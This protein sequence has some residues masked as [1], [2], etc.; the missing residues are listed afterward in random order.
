MCLFSGFASAAAQVTPV[1]QNCRVD[2]TNLLFDLAAWPG[3]YIIAASTNTAGAWIPE[4]TITVGRAGIVNIVVPFT[5]QKALFFGARG[6]TPSDGMGCLAQFQ[7]L[8]STF[9][10]EVG[11]DNGL[12]RQFQW[13]WSDGTTSSDYPIAAKDFGTPDARIQGLLANPMSSVASINLGFDG[14]DGGASTPLSNRP[15]QNV[16]AVLFPYPLPSLRYWASAYNPITNTLDFSGFTNLQVIECYSCTNLQHVVVTNLPALTRACIEICQL[17]E[18]DLS[19]NPEFQDLRGAF[20][21]YTNIIVGRGTGPKIRHWCVGRNPQLRQN[22]MDLI[23]NFY[24]LE[25]LIVSY[26]SQSGALAIPSTNLISVNASGNAYSVADFTGRSTLSECL[27]Y[28]NQ[29]TNVMLSGC[30]GLQYLDAHN[31]RISSID[32][33]D[34]PGLDYLDLHDNQLTTL[35]TTASIELEY[36]DAHGNQLTNAVLNGCAGL[37]FVDLHDN[38]LPAEILDDL[39]AFL[40]ASAPGVTNVNLTG[41]AGAPSAIGYDHYVSLTNRGVT[42]LVDW[43]NTNNVPG[44]PNAITFVTTSSDPHMEIRTNSGAAVSILWHWGDGATTTNSLLADHDFGSV[45]RFTNYV[46]VI[47]PSSVTYFG[48]QWTITG[49]GIEAVFGASNFPNLQYL[50]LYNESVAILSLAGCSNLVQLHLAGNPVPPDVCDQ[51]FI[52]LDNAVPGPVTSADFWYP[53]A[54]RSSASDA[55]WSSLAKKGYAMHPS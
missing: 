10:P 4:M 23:T 1:L 11:C 44:G 36:L 45:G 27:L 14:I 37:K 6:A 8:E 40:D 16:A 39:L 19:G 26:D 33:T 17:Q 42:V 21:A 3:D 38:R 29:L 24:S 22:L 47:P 54:S 28:D 43:P 13:I 55:A 9:E 30:T 46:E 48:A 12:P 7:T 35:I 50:Y 53:A 25:E 2:G 41:N 18:L 15:P 31:N 49:Q 51:W 52:D 5:G 20:N 34:C 32:L